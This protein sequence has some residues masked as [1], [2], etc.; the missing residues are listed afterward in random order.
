MGQKMA[1]TC[2]VK[3]DG[4]Q[5]AVEG[6]VEIPMMDVTRETKIGSTGVVGFSETPI[7]P[8]VNLS[9]FLQ[10]DFPIDKLKQTDLTVTAELANG[11][12]YTLQSAWL[13]G[14]VNLNPSDGNVTL[15]FVGLKGFINK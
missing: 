7:A 2:Y 9:A 10:N 12:V 5:L 13:S 4:E 8:F 6:S 14:E 3:V 1:G 15:N 11:W